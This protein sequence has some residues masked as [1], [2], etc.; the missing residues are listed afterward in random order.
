MEKNS[1]KKESY[2]TH[3]HQAIAT[4]S[5]HE[6]TQ[7][8]QASG[9]MYF[10]AP[11]TTSHRELHGPVYVQEENRRVGMTF[12]QEERRRE[13][14]RKQEEAKQEEERK[15]QFEIEEKMRQEEFKRAEEQRLKQQEL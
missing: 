2:G 8:T 9:G 11:A 6:Q 13:E 5:S 10:A 15:R 3:S 7:K 4:A 14:L 1:E 12:Q